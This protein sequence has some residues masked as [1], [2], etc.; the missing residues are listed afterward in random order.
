MMSKKRE[1]KKKKTIANA[2]NVAN[3]TEK[4]GRIILRNGLNGDFGS[5][6]MLRIE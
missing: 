1:L 6:K 4:R 5:V 3:D 2:L